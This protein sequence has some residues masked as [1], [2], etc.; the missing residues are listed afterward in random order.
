ME[1]QVAVVGGNKLYFISLPMHAFHM[2][3]NILIAVESSVT[4]ITHKIFH[5]KVNS[6][7]MLDQCRSQ[8]E[9]FRTF[10]A[11]QILLFPVDTLYVPLQACFIFCYIGTFT[12]WEFLVYQ[13]YIFQVQFEIGLLRESLITQIT[14]KVFDLFMDGFLM[15][16]KIGI[17]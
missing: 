3:F 8:T 16:L 5:L 12:A 13:M 11:H 2:F 1:N 6:S 14:Q 17:T 4:D 10:L 15:P 9:G 7:D